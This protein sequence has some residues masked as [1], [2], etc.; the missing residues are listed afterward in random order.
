VLFDKDNTLTNHDKLEVLPQFVPVLKSVQTLF[1]KEHVTVFSNNLRV[2]LVSINSKKADIPVLNREGGEKK[3]FILNTI[4]SY[5]R[6]ALGREID[7]SKLIVVGDR[8]LT[9]VYLG[10]SVGGLSILVLPWD[11]KREQA[12]I[13]IARLMENVVW[14]RV[15]GTRTRT[16]VNK[17][18]QSIAKDFIR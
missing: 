3:P 9:D 5:F 13:R 18:V 11:L 2:G 6:N 1:G 4:Q 16:H 10:N 8:L 12:G 17:E 7:P 14:N 15:F